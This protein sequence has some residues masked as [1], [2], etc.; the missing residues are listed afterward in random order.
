M[1]CPSGRTWTH[2]LWTFRLSTTKGHRFPCHSGDQHPVQSGDYIVHSLQTTQG[3][4][5][6]KM[7]FKSACLCLLVKIWVKPN[8]E[9]ILCCFTFSGFLLDELL[10]RTWWRDVSYQQKS[11][12]NHSHS[13]LSF[14]PYSVWFLSSLAARLP[15]SQHKRQEAG[16]CSSGRIFSGSLSHI[17]CTES[18]DFSGRARRLVT[19]LFSFS[20]SSDRL[21]IFHPT[22]H[23]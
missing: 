4:E 16:L 14:L 7:T 5:W 22:R 19:V 15:G 10:K 13:S 12:P 21:S 17:L 3:R 2:A 23:R 6:N 9:F 11:S 1:T 18:W 20:I 8:K